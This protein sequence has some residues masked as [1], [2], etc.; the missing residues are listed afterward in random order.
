MRKPFGGRKIVQ[1]LRTLA[2]SLAGSVTGLKWA[3]KSLLMLNA[4][5]SPISHRVTPGEH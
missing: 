3:Q 1:E 5:E 4:F 2:L